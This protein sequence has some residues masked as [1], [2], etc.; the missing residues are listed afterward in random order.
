MRSLISPHHRWVN[1]GD[2]AAKPP[3]YMYDTTKRGYPDVTLNGH[4]YQV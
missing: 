4:N 3:A 2:D 1:N